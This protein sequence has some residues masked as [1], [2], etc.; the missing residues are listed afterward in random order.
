MRTQLNPVLLI[1]AASVLQSCAATAPPVVH[2]E[3]K[4][5]VT[6]FNNANLVTM[7]E[8]GVVND[9]AVVIRDGQIAQIIQEQALDIDS[10][11]GDVT[12]IDANGGYLAPGY[13]DAHYHF[14]HRD[15]LL[16]YLAYGVT[17]VINLGQ[18]GHKT[19]ELLS[20]RDVISS[21][22]MPGPQIYTT[23]EIISNGI[24]S[25]LR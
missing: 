3:T 17:T 21:G 10:V 11:E 19:R 8:Q 12:V 9:M 22:D 1:V 6:I 2:S 23:A 13:V 14:R 5:T 18:A 4:S 15:E 7:T 24:T 16:N 20:L 25:T